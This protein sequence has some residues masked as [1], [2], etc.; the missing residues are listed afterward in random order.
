LVRAKPTIIA[1]TVVTVILIG[2]LAGV[3]GCSQ[4]DLARSATLARWEL[5]LQ[6]RDVTTRRLAEAG[7]PRCFKDRM[8]SSSIRKDVLK[9]EAARGGAPVEAQVFGKDLSTMPG[10]QGQF[11]LTQKDFIHVEGA[12]LSSCSDVPCIVNQIYGKPGSDAGWLV[13]GWFLKMG[14]MISLMDHVPEDPR[15]KIEPVKDAR[16]AFLFPEKELLAFWRM[17]SLLPPKFRAVRTVAGIHRY[18]PKKKSPSP[19]WS[20]STCASATW[21]TRQLATARF[22]DNVGCLELESGGVSLSD[23]FYLSLGHEFAHTLDATIGT[24]EEPASISDAWLGIGGWTFAIEIDPTVKKEMAVHDV[25]E[26]SAKKS[27]FVSSYARS[28]PLEDWAETVAHFRFRAPALAKASPE[29]MKYVSENLYNGRIFTPEGLTRYYEDF[30]F[31]Q[32]SQNVLELVDACLA[33][34]ASGEGL[35]QPSLVLSDVAP[36]VQGCLDRQV[37][38][39]ITRALDELRAEEYEACDLLAT[40]EGAL[41]GRLVAQINPEVGKILAQRSALAPMLQASKQ[42]RAALAAQL[43]PREAYLRCFRKPDPKGC[44]LTAMTD[45]FDRVASPVAVV[46]GDQL[47]KEREDYLAKNSFEASAERTAVFYQNVFAGI[48]PVIAEAAQ[49]RWKECLSTKTDGTAFTEELLTQP[50]SG[51]ARFVEAALLNCINAKVIPDLDAARERYLKRL[52]L[53]LSDSDTQYFLQQSLL[54]EYLRHLQAFV[55]ESSFIEDGE[56]EERRAGVIDVLIG[57]LTSKKDWYKPALTLSD[58]QAKCGGAA[59]AAF[60]GYFAKLSPE[61]RLPTRFAAWEDVRRQWA[62]EACRKA[63]QSLTHT[64][65]KTLWSAVMGDLEAMMLA[66]TAPVVSQCNKSYPKKA[67]GKQRRSCLVGQWE[68][69]ESAALSNWSQTESGKIFASPSKSAQAH[70]TSRKA[71]LQASAAQKLD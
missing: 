29:R 65:P 34:P 45:A 47:P 61:K 5:L 71:A 25:W 17:S 62:A 15:D 53:S 12:D 16:S 39:K 41:R 23:E 13:Y 19:N 6:E 1:M 56:R 67:N 32:L 20:G 14:S 46:L 63:F 33:N 22:S 7:G 35:S 9:L 50:F 3:G 28:S 37:H 2:S 36:L 70:L 57:E 54:P 10:P 31:R 21:G 48:A 58:L 69:I 55:D 44:Y 40:T 51:S 11:L 18:P 52:G 30:A 27:T 8:S 42:L 24:E 68:K 49:A 64:D 60:D 38:Q 4:A 66:E 59:A 43:D 26:H